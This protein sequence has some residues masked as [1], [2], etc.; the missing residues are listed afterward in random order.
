VTDTYLRSP[1]LSGDRVVFVADDDVWTVAAAGGVAARLTADRVPVARPRLSP[2]GTYVAWTSRREGEPEVFVAPTAGGAPQRLTWWGS[3]QTRLLGWTAEG[4]VVAATPSGSPF[5]THGWAYALPVTGES[6]ERLPYGPIGGLAQSAAG[7]TVLQSVI[8][9]E[10]ATWKR[11]RGGTA[12]KLWI[13]AA[14]SGTFQRFLTELDGQLVDPVWVGDRLAFLSDHEGHGNVY[15]VAADGGDLRRHSDHTGAYA[16]DLAGSLTGDGSQAVYAR[17]GELWLLGDLAADSTPT[18][19]VVELPGARAARQRR[20]VDVKL[21]QLDL[22][23]DLEGRGSVVGARGTVQWLP[24][25]DGPARV[26]HAVDGVRARTPRVVPTAPRTAVWVT[27]AEGDDALEVGDGATS[28]VLAAGRVGRVLEL[29]VAPDGASAA[30]ATHEGRV[31]RVDLVKGDVT[32]VAAEVSDASGLAFSPDGSLLAWSAPSASGLRQIRL[33]DLGNGTVVDATPLRFVDTEPV[34]TLDGRHL[35]FLSA[36]TFDPIYDAQAFELSFPV[37]VRPYLLPLRGAT[38]SP[39]DPELEGRAVTPPEAGEPATGFDAEGLQ[40]RVVPV[41]GAAGLYS[42]LR[43]AE[44]GL[45]WLANPLAGVLGQDRPKSDRRR[46]SL[47]RWD[48]GTRRE[49]TIVPE[50][51]GYEVS[52]DGKRIAVRDGEALRIGPADRP[53][54]PSEQPEAAPTDLVEVDLDRLRVKPEPVAEWR[55]MTT[56]TWR[57]MRDHFWIADMGGV[58]WDD[59]LGRYLP[60]VNRL[61][62]RDDLS[63]LLWEMIGELGASHCYER[64]PVSPPPP[65]GAAAFLGADLERTSDGW[66]VVSVLPADTSVPAARSPLSA[67]SVG[68]QPG[69][70]LVAIDG[71]LISDAGVG[72]LLAG[73]ADLP[74]ELTVR[75][76]K[77]ERVV[78]VVPLPDELPVRYQQWVAGRRREVHERTGGR[79]GYV[80]IPDMMS[81]GW[82]EF[83]R[84]LRAE[85]ERDA[86]VVDTRENG[87]GHVSQLVLERLSRKPIGGDVVRH[88]PEESWPGQA[89]KGPLVSLANEYAGSDGDIVNQSFKEMGLGPVVGVRTWGG[90]IGIDGRYTLVDGSS[91]TQPRYSFWFRGAGWGVE[92]YGV[93]PDIEVPMPPQAWVAGEDPQLDEGLRVVTE[94]LASYPALTR[95]PLESRPDRSIPP[96]PPRP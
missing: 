88:G 9:R 63:E 25:Q 48:F 75:S 50:L 13:D 79:V 83:H 54:K 76:G 21:E 10:A 3:A 57:L 26:L 51:D 46:P 71:Q 23:V 4:R 7:A 19:L 15:S 78:V 74:V 5:R 62:T 94:A 31:L 47:R 43:A 87:G 24:H 14:G 52:G 85:L 93:D 72:P 90:V 22:A 59:V 89:A 70:V 49:L 38:P 69:D 17:S 65:G 45:L 61:A 18:Q 95:P 20:R 41:P 8:L 12:G 96:L 80:H 30:I 64:P 2:D 67:P 68:V 37:A 66:R 34:F 1:H 16:R 29:V 56:E 32:E 6:G 82:A 91:V 40:E 81:T 58:D 36:R 77:D 44:G 27:D 73:R 28:R 53:V 11:Y 35:A 86:L 33:A 84:D 92:N 60:V 42:S 55:Q 39:F